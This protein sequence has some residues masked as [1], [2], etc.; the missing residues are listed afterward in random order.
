MISPGDHMI[1]G[2]YK[3]ISISIT[4]KIGYKYNNIPSFIT[5]DCVIKSVI[6]HVEH[7]SPRCS[8]VELYLQHE[9]KASPRLVV[10]YEETFEESRFDES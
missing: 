5:L 2:I 1:E 7:L 6:I 9:T 4:N 8:K 3:Y 10:E